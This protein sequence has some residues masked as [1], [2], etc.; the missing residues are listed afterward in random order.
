[1]VGTACRFRPPT[2]AGTPPNR[3]SG[4]ARS[5]PTSAT[6]RP[7]A[8][9]AGVNEGESRAT[10]RVHATDRLDLRA[11]L[12]EQHRHGGRGAHH[13]RR[14]PTPAR[15][16]RT[17]GSSNPSG[18]AGA[19]PTQLTT[20]PLSCS[21]AAPD[22]RREPIDQAGHHDQLRIASLVLLPFIAI[23]IVIS[24]IWSVLCLGTRSLR[25]RV[26]P[27]FLTDLG[28]LS[29]FVLM[30]MTSR[31]ADCASAGSGDTL[32]AARP[33]ACKWRGD[34]VSLRLGGRIGHGSSWRSWR[35]RRTRL[36]CVWMRSSD[37]GAGPDPEDAADAGPVTPSNAPTTTSGT[38]PPP[39]SP[40]SRSLPA[41][42]SG[43]ASNGTATR[44]S[45]PSSNTS[46]RRCVT[47]RAPPPR[48][49]PGSAVRKASCP[50]PTRRAST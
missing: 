45:W 46:P 37:P 30:N 40:P 20:K 24:L 39:C 16:P 29:I 43:S 8:G 26:L 13:H 9:V 48:R 22:A 4:W 21:P 34:E 19:A 31:V 12:R 5:S 25:L 14:F 11:H 41:R 23:L 15:E 32:P 6:P 18:P 38:A 47:S 10:A 44:S 2:A 27:H 35:R 7:A 1:V 36:C 28:D 49:P 17:P 33:G 50:P 42:S 3:R